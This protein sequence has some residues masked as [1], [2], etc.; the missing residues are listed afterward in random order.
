MTSP[1]VHE[2]GLPWSRDRRRGAGPSLHRHP[3]PE[4]IVTQEG[5][6]T[7]LLGEEREPREVRAGEMVV[8]PAGQ[9]HAFA[10]S[11]D[12]PLRQLDIH[13]SASFDTEWLVQ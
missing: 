13:L 10:N 4:V 7:F 11:G 2:R 9:W 8:I 6:A 1:I 12:G 5:S 3:Y